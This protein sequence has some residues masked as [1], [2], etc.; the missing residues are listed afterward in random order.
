MGETMPV[1][2]PAEFDK[3][4]QDYRAQHAQSTGVSEAE[5]DYFA[6]Y[7][8]E[9]VKQLWQARGRSPRMI[10]DF[11]AGIGNALAP[12][13]EA[14]PDAEIIALDV[15]RASL[16]LVDTQAI[17]NVRTLAYDGLKVPL[18]DASL[19]CVFI[20][21]VFHHIPAE[22]HIAILAE[23]RR[24]LRPDG[25]I[26]LFEHNPLNP[27]TRLAV[28]R[29]EFDRDAVL[30]GAG[31]MR[32]RMVAAGFVRTRRT[33]CLFFPPALKVLSPLERFLGWLPLG[34]Q[35]HLVES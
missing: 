7:K 32:R 27:L 1:H 15:S 9:H 22:H 14:F 12:M 20:A 30:I 13:H 16:D 23:L 3:V 29:C 10:M 18:P 24:V 5:L 26:V 11:G 6:S 28:A 31:E 17:P 21:C 19:D 25:V 2:A 8:I 34:A 33:F 4:A 35:Y